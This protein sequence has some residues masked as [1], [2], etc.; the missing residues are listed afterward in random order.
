R[1]LR[2][3]NSFQT[4]FCNTHIVL[5]VLQ[6]MYISDF[7]VLYLSDD[8]PEIN[9]HLCTSLKVLFFRVHRLLMVLDIGDIQLSH[10]SSE[11]LSPFS[12]ALDPHIYFLCFYFSSFP[13]F[14]NVRRLLLLALT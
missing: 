13:E 14:L 1:T 10:S 4:G 5:L 2:E 3:K 6:K 9:L 8:K 12:I 7:L 11:N